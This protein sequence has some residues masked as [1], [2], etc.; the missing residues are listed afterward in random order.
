MDRGRVRES[1]EQ[2]GQG[3]AEERE[4][5]IQGVKRYYR[6]IKGMRKIKKTN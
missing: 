4:E 6:G 5:H 2:A 3:R 1:K